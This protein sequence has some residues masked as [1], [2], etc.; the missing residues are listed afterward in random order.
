MKALHL[1]ISTWF[2]LSL[3]VFLTGSILHLHSISDSLSDPRSLIGCLPDQLRPSGVLFDPVRNS[4]LWDSG[5]EVNQRIKI[6]LLLPDNNS[7]AAKNGADLAV[8]IANR[9]NDNG[10]N[11]ELVVRS[12]EGQWGTGSKQAV[13]L[14]F[15]DNVTAILGLH[16][17]RNAHLVEQVSAKSRAVFLSAWSADPTLAQSFVPWFFNCV[18]NDAQV[19]DAL[20]E[21]IYTKKKLG[22]IVVVSDNSYDSQ[23]TLRNF[24]YKVKS[25]G[26]PEPQHL[27]VNDNA[28]DLKDITG[29]LQS[30]NID[31]IILFVQPPASLKLI[32]QIRLNNIFRPVYGTLGL[33]DE[34]KIPLHDLKLYD[35]VLCASPLNFMSKSGALFVEEYRKKFGVR[36]G[37]VAAYAFDGMNI[38]IEAIRKGGT[39]REGLQK[40]MAG[41]KFEGVTGTIQF[42]DKGNR[43]GTPGF[44]EIK[45]GI[46]IPLSR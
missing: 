6:G 17:G 16:D 43:I 10:I 4:P 36:P 40:A 19:S 34:N 12:M 9:K 3:Q 21:E 20:M 24:L 37:A 42:D 41:I 45:N 11:F 33:L 28:N 26:N 38:L 8:L 27:I 29:Q 2:V 46:L 22:K 39:E 1:I 7:L 44:V 14:I 32:E 35:N 23:S 25:S 13:T 18:Y 15:D 31:C 5:V 30:D